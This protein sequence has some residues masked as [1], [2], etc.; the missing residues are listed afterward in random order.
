VASPPEVRHGR[1]PIL[2]DAGALGAVSG[3]ARTRR[4]VRGGR[5][6]RAA[7][8]RPRRRQLLPHTDRLCCARLPHEPGEASPVTPATQGS[9]GL[10]PVQRYP[11]LLGS[12]SSTTV[13]PQIR[14]I[15]ALTPPRRSSTPAQSE[16]GGS[17]SSSSRAAGTANS[18][19]ARAARGR[20][21]L[22]LSC[23]FPHVTR[24][25]AGRLRASIPGGRV[26]RSRRS[27]PAVRSRARGGGGRYL[28]SRRLTAITD[29]PAAMP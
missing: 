1:V 17:H 28:S 12:A 15:R 5:Y 11:S 4:G 19:A 26:M 13:L 23:E 10:V 20:L 22:L 29:I 18:A 14:T 21:I 9:A 6:R 27:L 2:C 8:V 16:K 3:T 24:W 7:R 25:A